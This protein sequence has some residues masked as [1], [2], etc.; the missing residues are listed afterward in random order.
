MIRKSN[1][2]FIIFAIALA[3]AAGEE[4]SASQAKLSAAQIVD[5]NVEA[6]GGLQAW[7][8]VHTLSFVG[9]LGAGGNQRS[10]SSSAGC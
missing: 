7:R 4:Q 6:R 8:S 9:R 2:I 3:V 1:E 5:K 10:Y